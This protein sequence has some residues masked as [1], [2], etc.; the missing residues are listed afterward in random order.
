[1]DD[2][3]ST[4]IRQLA[5]GDESAAQKIWDRYCKQLLTLARKRLGEG[6]RRVADEEDAV[7]SAF[8]SF[9][10]GAAAGRFPKLDDRDDLWK[11]LVTITSRKVFAH[12]RHA[13]RQRRGGGVVRG[14]SVF[15]R[16]AAFGLAVGVPL[17][18][19]GCLW[20]MGLSRR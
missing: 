3:V 20:I 15:G 14:E 6:Q 10:R 7:L 5:Q 2:D 19:V 18:V 16:G 17:G 11:L 8:H 13:R 1:M 12:Q 4:W 9:C